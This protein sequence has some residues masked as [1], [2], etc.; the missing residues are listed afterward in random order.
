MYIHAVSYT[1][2]DVYK[3]QQDIPC[4]AY[5]HNFEYSRDEKASKAFLNFEGIDS[6]FYVWLNGSYIGYSQVS[7]MTSEFDV[8]DVLQDG[9]NTVAVLVMKWCDGSYLEDQDKFRMSGIF[10]VSY[11]HLGMFTE[12]MEQRGPGHTCGGEQVFTTGY[13]DYKEKKMCIRD[14]KRME[15]VLGYQSFKT[16]RD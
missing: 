1:H 2:L 3:R 8:T 15:S 4:G 13:M 9:M 7:H 12:F 10:P 6:C 14:R 5:V 16:G 11:T